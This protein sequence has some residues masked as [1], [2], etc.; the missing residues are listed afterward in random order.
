MRPQIGSSTVPF[1]ITDVKQPPE[2]LASIDAVDLKGESWNSGIDVIVPNHTISNSEEYIITLEGYK[3]NQ[4]AK[5]N[6]NILEVAKKHANIP[7]GS[8]MNVW[9][10]KGY[11]D[12]GLHYDGKDGILTVLR[13]T[14]HLTLYPPTDTPYLRPLDILPRWA[15]QT[16]TKAHYNLY[17]LSRHLPKT[18]Y[19]SARIL[20]ESVHNKS[21]LREITKM[22]NEV[23][24][25][26]IWGC[27]LQDGVLRWEIYAYH[28]DIR[29]NE[30]DNPEL[31]GFR[32]KK[33]TPCLIHSID[34]L[35]RDDPIGP[36]IH[37]YYKTSEG[38]GFPIFG[39]GTTGLEIPEGVFCIDRRDQLKKHY[40]TYSQKIGFKWE[41]VQ[42]CSVLLDKYRCKELVIWNKYK[43]QIYIQYLGISLSDFILFLQE[44]KYPE[45]L[46]RHVST[47][48]YKD[49]EHEITIV[50][51]METLQPVRT[52]FYGIL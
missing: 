24:S 21:V 42:K 17:Q 40:K 13:G 28:F 25:P 38:T 29:D 49:I 34:L 16:A 19:P 9:I 48:D 15:K 32:L 1:M 3:T 22:K 50:Y 7:P 26:L 45:R 51:D 41:D 47:H 10:S 27:K 23:K 33:K 11:N 30:R 36:D 44:H 46:I 5:L 52:G 39:S 4:F 31:G 18:T 37:Y 20:Y 8:E 6:E 35:D 43:H 14:K 2:L 12:S